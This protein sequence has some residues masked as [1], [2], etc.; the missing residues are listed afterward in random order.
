MKVIEYL[1]LNGLNDLQSNYNIKVKKYKEEGLIVLNYDQV[2]S[3]KNILTDDCRGLILALHYPLVSR[4]FARFSPSG[5]RPPARLPSPF[6]VSAPSLA[7]SSPFLSLPPGLFP[8]AARPLPPAPLV[9][10]PSLCRSCFARLPFSSR[11]LSPLLSR[12]FRSPCPLSFC[13]PCPGPSPCSPFCRFS[14]LVFP[15]PRSLWSFF[16][17]RPLRSLVSSPLVFSRAFSPALWVFL[18]RRLSSPLLPF[19]SFRRRVRSFCPFSSSFSPSPSPLFCRSPSFPRRR[20]VS[21]PARQ[22]LSLLPAHLLPLSPLFPR[23]CPP[24]PFCLPPFLPTPCPPRSPPFPLPLF[25]ASPSPPRL[26]PSCSPPF[27]SPFAFG[28]SPPVPAPAFPFPFSPRP[29]SPPRPSLF[30]LRLVPPLPLPPPLFPPPSFRPPSPPPVPC[31]PPRPLLPPPAP[32]AS[33]LPPLPPLPFSLGLRGSGPRR[34]APPSPAAVALP[35]ARFRFFFFC[36]GLAPWAPSPFPPSPAPLLP[37]PCLALWPRLFSPLPLSLSVLPLSPPLSS[38]LAPPRPCC[39]FFFCRPSFPLPL[40]PAFARAL[41]RGGPSVGRALFLPPSPLWFPL[42]PP[43]S[44][45]LPLLSPPLSSVLS[46]APLPPSLVVLL[47]LLLPFV[48][49]FLAPRFS[50]CSPPGVLPLP[51]RLSFCPAA[52]PV[53]APLPSPG[54]PLFFPRP[55][56]PL[57]IFLRPPPA[58]RPAPLLPAAFF[59]NLSLPP[60]ISSPPLLLVPSR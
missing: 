8:P 43:P 30:S 17:S 9:P 28:A 20:L 5:A 49:L 22:P 14:L 52:L 57:P 37:P 48:P 53:V 42:P 41:R 11:R 31:P 55:C 33:L 35:R 54:F 18:S 36:P 7:V 51:Y 58:P 16:R 47:L 21:S 46:L 44:L 60:G 26:C 23:R 19:P 27:W 39:W 38:C 15:C 34:A 1:K 45:F 3:P 59:G 13:R 6:P 4:A 40:A 29:P 12:S 50:P 25:S 10:L 56:P 32:P 24:F 2:F